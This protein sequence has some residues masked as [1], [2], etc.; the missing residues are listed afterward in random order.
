MSHLL[1]LNDIQPGQV[2]LVAL[3]KE[4]GYFLN[5]KFPTISHGHFWFGG[6][7]QGQNDTHISI[8]L[9]AFR[10]L[11]TIDIEAVMKDNICQIPL[12]N[13]ERIWWFS[14]TTWIFLRS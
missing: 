10:D 9:K 2:V 6:L 14:G 13:I 5:Q 8:E 7:F 3:D 11:A 1:E 12:G 4:E